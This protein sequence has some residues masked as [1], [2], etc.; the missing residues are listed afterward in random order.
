[1]GSIA[2]PSTP[3]AVSSESPDSSV[4]SSYNIT[5]PCWT[6]CLYVCIQPLSH[7][8]YEMEQFASREFLRSSRKFAKNIH[9]IFLREDGI[10]QSLKYIR[11]N[12]IVLKYCTA[13]LIAKIDAVNTF[14]FTADCTGMTRVSCELTCYISDIAVT[15]DLHWM[16]YENGMTRL[17]CYTSLTAEGTL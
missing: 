10:A 7:T 11:K 16:H 8:Y 3:S 2:G 9:R 15:A 1:M 6:I 17:Q 13:G 5:T 12:T 14:H 4:C